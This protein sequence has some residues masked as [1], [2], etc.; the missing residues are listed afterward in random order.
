[1][2]VRELPPTDAGGV[3]VLRVLIFGLFRSRPSLQAG[4]RTW[5]PRV[6]YVAALRRLAGNGAIATRNAARSNDAA[7][8]GRR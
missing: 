5:V 7:T 3:D 1:M 6:A 4:L 2:Q 8:L